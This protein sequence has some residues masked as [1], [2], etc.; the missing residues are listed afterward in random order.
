M[1]YLFLTLALLF[2]GCD[3]QPPVV[4]IEPKTPVQPLAPTPQPF[5][6]PSQPLAQVHGKKVKKVYQAKCVGIVDGDTIDVLT[7][8][9]E[10]VRIRLDSIDTPEPKQA[11][12]NAAKQHTS[13]LVF[14][15]MLTVH[16]T[17]THFERQVAFVFA[18]DVDVCSELVSVG[19]AWNSVKYSKS[20]TLPA[21]EQVA[22]DKGLGLWADAEPVPPW[23]F[24][25][26]K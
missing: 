15:K 10:Q 11:F 19:L 9:N 4:V 5:T 25:K 6:M 26:Q 23:E 22:R 21:I 3:H 16:K 14:G 2:V 13:S 17:G 1:R 18:G 20:E 8:D 24:R 12:A 7:A